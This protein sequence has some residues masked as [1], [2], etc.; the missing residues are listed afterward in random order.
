MVNSGLAAD[1]FFPFRPSELLCTNVQTA[2]IN[3]SLQTATLYN[4]PDFSDVTIK[5][6]GREIYCHKLILCTESAYF[7]KLCGP[8]GHF[9]V[10]QFQWQFSALAESS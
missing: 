2:T 7:A 8:G 4:K 10:C 1:A 3:M 6:S 5:F 9:A